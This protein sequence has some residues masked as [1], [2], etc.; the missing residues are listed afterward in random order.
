MP[1]H[2]GLKP[3]GR[4][5]SRATAEQ[6]RQA[7]AAYKKQYRERANRRE[8]GR[9]ALLAS[10]SRWDLPLSEMLMVEFVLQPANRDEG[11]RMRCKFL[12]LHGAARNLKACPPNKG[13][14]ELDVLAEV[15]AHQ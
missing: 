4:V 8:A 10:L 15:C 14:A 7:R 6:L 11:W 9:V 5:Q 12:S 1:P 3:R 2:D 13:V